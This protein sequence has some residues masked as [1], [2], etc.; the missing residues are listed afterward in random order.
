[1]IL[2]VIVIAAV[3]VG[4][5]SPYCSCSCKKMQDRAA[6]TTVEQTETTD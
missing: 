6:E 1:M 3:L 5:M 4:L 2:R